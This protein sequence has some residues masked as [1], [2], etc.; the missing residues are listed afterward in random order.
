LLVALV[1]L[2]EA[3]GGSL[4]PPGPPAPTMKTLDEIRSIPVESLGGWP[5]ATYVIQQPGSYYLT[6]NLVGEAGKTGILIHT[7]A[8]DVTLDLN[9]FAVIGPGSA[10]FGISVFA[11]RT[12]IRNGSVRD[13]GNASVAVAA[14]DAIIES[15]VAFN[16][17]AGF[18]LQ[19]SGAIVHG[20][21]A[22][23]NTT[24]FLVS[25]DSVTVKDS[26]AIGNDVF[27]ADLLGRGG[28]LENSSL[29]HEP[30]PTGVWGSVRIDGTSNTVIN[31]RIVVNSADMKGIFV[32]ANGAGARIEDN[33][34][35]LTAVATNATAIH[36]EAPS[37]ISRNILTLE[38]ADARGVELTLAPSSV[39]RN[40]ISGTGLNIIAILIGL[41]EG[42]GVTDN[43]ITLSGT[44]GTGIS[45]AGG[46]GYVERNNISILGASGTGIT[47][48][49]IQMNVLME[50][51]FVMLRS[52]NGVGISVGAAADDLI[53]SNTVVGS[54]SHYVVGSGNQDAQMLSNPG[55]GFT[56][57][58][59]ANLAVGPNS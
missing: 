57:S 29:W 17:G 53:L 45:I 49:I 52:T 2:G 36:A 20:C 24:G 28:L 39:E 16:N 19:E 25:G 27:D 55:S 51:N 41:S 5:T 31:N 6:R 3:G 59:S 34:V 30:N 22:R 4:E 12:V 7:T 26:T 46:S 48:G 11:P 47:H 15:V 13:W 9:G 8:S 23:E 40:F 18:Q 14:P 56:I 44:S 38:G 21:T 54:G 10:D 1:A 50:D 58:G 42:N 37:M 43:R 32:S 33:N 35:G